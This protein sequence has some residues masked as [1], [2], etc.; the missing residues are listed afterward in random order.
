MFP[1]QKVKEAEVSPLTS[2]PKSQEDANNRIAGFSETSL[3][4][5]LYTR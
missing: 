3:S 1:D 5:L 4:L 2:L